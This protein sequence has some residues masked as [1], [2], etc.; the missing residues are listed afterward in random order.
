MSSD[1]T[2]GL[3]PVLNSISSDGDV[4]SNKLQITGFDLLNKI[5]K[6]TKFKDLSKQTFKNFKTHFSIHDGK[7]MLTPFDL[8]LGGIDTKISG[9]TTLEKEMNYKFAMNVP[10]S[11]IPASILKEVEKGLTMLNGLHPSLKIG[12]LPAFI[13]VNVFASGDVKNPKITTDLKEQVAAAAKAQLGNLIDDIK[14]TVIDSVT[15]IIDDKIDDIKAEI[16]KQ[17][18]A[19]LADAQKKANDLKA[20]AKKAANKIRTEADAHGKQL[21]KEAGS[22]PIK[23]KLAQIAAKK[24][25]DE[26]EKKAVAVEKE[27]DK[28]ADAIMKK[29]REQADK[30][31]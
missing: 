22:N 23:K 6:V 3:M 1:L 29:A 17:K 5:Q 21:M 2:S 8:K 15:A 4:S 20:G 9:Y 25:T 12:D 18:K 31:G 14:A 27:G 16:E 24:Y 11:K 13:P 19:I 7:V 28:K 26:A 30:L 10:K